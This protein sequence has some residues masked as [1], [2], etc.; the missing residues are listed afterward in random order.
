VNSDKW[1]KYSVGTNILIMSI[2][3]YRKQKPDFLLVLPYHFLDE[4]RA[5]EKEFLRNGGKMIVSI[6]DFKII[7]K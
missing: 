3:D 6:P 4:I 2:E 5:Q 1:G 7:D